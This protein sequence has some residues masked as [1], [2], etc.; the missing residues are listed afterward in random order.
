MQ[1]LY[2]SWISGDQRQSRDNAQIRD[3]TPNDDGWVVNIRTDP[4]NFYSIDAAT[5]ND[6]VFA[7]L[8]CEVRVDGRL[9]IEDDS[10]GAD[11]QV[12]CRYTP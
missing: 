5:I 2:I 7:F 11:A 10:S 6:D 8:R 9:V 1:N 4:S 12:N 3:R